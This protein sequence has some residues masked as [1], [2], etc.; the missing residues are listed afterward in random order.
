[1]KPQKTIFLTLIVIL[2]LTL[3]NI[4]L[5]T[6]TPEVRAAAPAGYELRWY[7]EF[8]GTSLNTNE[9]YYRNDSKHWST[10]R[11]ENVSL[12]NG[13]LKIALKKESYGG[14]NYTGGGI[15]SKKNF[16]YGYYEVRAKLHPASGWHSAFWAMD[17]HENAD[18][19]PAEALTEV[20]Q[21][22]VDSVSPSS[23]RHNVI[24]WNPTAGT[25]TSG[26]YN[27]GFNTAQD[28][29]IY[30]F[31]W[32]S[33]QVK[34]Y[35][36]GALKYTANYPESYH[37]H[38]T[39]KI[40]LTCI[41][42]WLGNTTY[43][44]DTALPGEILFDYIRYYAPSASMS[45]LALVK[46][47]TVDS[48]YDVMYA[49]QKA[50]DGDNH[51][52]YSRWLSAD[53]TNPHWIKLDLGQTYQ[54]N[55]IKFW[56]GYQ[57]YNNPLTNYTLQY[58]NGSSW[59]NIVN[60]TGNSQASVDEQFTPVSAREVRLYVNPGQLVRL[61][62][63]QVF[64]GAATPT[65]TPAPTPTPGTDIIIDNGDFGYTESGSNWYN[66][67]VPGYNGTI[68]RYNYQDSG[69]YAKWTPNILTA[70]NY[71][72]Y[73]YKVV[74][75]N[76]DT[77]AKIDVVHNGTTSTTYLNYTTGSSGWVYLGEWYFP[78]GTGGYVKNTRSNNTARADAV[79]F[80]KM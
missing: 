54:V 35:V 78:T 20:D 21:F 71:Q 59:V 58:W 73:I 2:T 13:N 5:Q 18:T 36:D 24:P 34:F 42:S 7:D 11:P 33:T 46:T 27:V 69:A 79:K 47:A 53:N 74:Y 63:I 56:T 16:Q 41:A 8:N 38:G 66:S 23:I 77:N 70:G 40:W 10:Q 22:E 43:V 26:I 25:L 51:C 76:S 60:R 64:S 62:E 75:A 57:G 50:V 17:H 52:D 67:S 15:I 28:F 19:W 48:T 39:V 4:L 14:M 3:S 30:G 65:P 45:N 6:N 61:Y 72:V 68:S 49:G 80:V 29:H 12:V 44:D 31:E 1:M 55:R 32:T 9:W 37:I